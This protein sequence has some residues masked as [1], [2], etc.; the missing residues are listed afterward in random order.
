MATACT[1]GDPPIGSTRSARC[2]SRST[3][4]TVNCSST[5]F[6]VGNALAS[7][8][9]GRQ[10][11]CSLSTRT[12]HTQ[13]IRGLRDGKVVYVLATNQTRSHERDAPPAMAPLFQI[14]GDEN[15]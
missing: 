11:A 10:G 6:A 1:V 15:M 8:P 9:F 14:S 5:H 4:L 13:V 3:N 12:D 2:G 7:G